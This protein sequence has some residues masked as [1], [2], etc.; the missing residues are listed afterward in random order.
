[1][2][3]VCELAASPASTK[4]SYGSAILQISGDDFGLCPTSGSAARLML[5]PPPP[6]PI[7]FNSS[8]LEVL[9]Q[10]PR[11]DWSVSVPPYPIGVEHSR[12]D[13]A[14]DFLELLP[15]PFEKLKVFILVK[16][17]SAASNKTKRR[18]KLLR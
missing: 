15:V 11:F 17:W 3:G 14:I 13:R 1:M 12:H 5:I 2:R 4:I 8:L 6:R 16:R 18:P 9:L 7:S 10:R